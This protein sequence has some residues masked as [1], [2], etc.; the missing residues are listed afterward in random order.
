MGRHKI[1]VHLETP[2]TLLFGL[3][4]RQTAVIGIGIAL[5]YIVVSTFWRNPILLG[6]AITFAAVLVISALLLAFIKPKN[7]TLDAWLVVIINF[8]LIPH[9]YAWRPLP[10]EVLSERSEARR[11]AQAQAQAGD[12]D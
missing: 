5:A 1:P 12:E 8:W 10:P 4:A 3:T 9:H 2:D 6:L 7:R 11:V